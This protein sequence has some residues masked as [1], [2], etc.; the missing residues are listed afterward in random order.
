MVKKLPY[1]SDIS[2]HPFLVRAVAWRYAA[3]SIR[4]TVRTK[5]RGL[6]SLRSSGVRV[7]L[8]SKLRFKPPRPIPI[9]KMCFHHK[10]NSSR[11]FGWYHIRRKQANL[12]LISYC[13]VFLLPRH[14]PAG[15]LTLTF[16]IR[17]EVVVPM[18]RINSILMSVTCIQTE[19]SQV[20]C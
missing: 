8:E 13:R 6:Y 20:F 17:G 14:E 12:P 10:L 5:I 15:S 7:G 18:Q 2:H 4:I 11:L 3:G 19:F 9:G 1:R 16:A